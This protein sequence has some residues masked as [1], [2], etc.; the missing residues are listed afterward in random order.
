MK[1]D[2]FLLA[3]ALAAFA[4][5]AAP[6]LGA[7]HGPLH[8]GVLGDVAVAL[9]FLLHGAAVSPK[10]MISAAA[11]WRLHV[12]VQS[13]TYLVFPLLGL[14]VWLASPNW[15]G[16][17][18]RIG[19]F[20]LCA[21]SSTISSSVAMTAMARGNVPA[22]IFNATL[23]GLL[24][25]VLTPFLMGGV[26][27]GAGETSPLLDQINSVVIKLLVPFVVGQALRGLLA[28]FLDRYKT[29]VGRVDRSVIVLIV[30][31]A[32]CDAAEAGIWTRA[33]ILSLLYLAL[34]CGVTLALVLVLTTWAS[35]RLGL[36]KADEIAAVFCGSKK[37]LANGA[38]IAKAIWG[39]S[40]ALGLI[41]V[42]LLLYHQMQL[43]VCAVIARRYAA[44]DKN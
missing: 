29:L 34:L 25:I 10:A 8:M 1:P 35:R 7:S 3:I 22:A 6:W 39:S 20:F 13:T 44:D 40:P 37:S 42:P 31:T 32:F 15:L 2:G 26:L 9:V 23:S 17:E 36:A 24:G 5:F 14:A 27:A 33:D 30:Y 43:I 4:A 18:F 19:Y 38:P 28:G 11:Q 41:L 16:N 21:I 12:M